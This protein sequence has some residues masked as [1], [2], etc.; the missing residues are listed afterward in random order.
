MKFMPLEP[1][2]VFV[3]GRNKDINIRHCANINLEADEQVTFVTPSGTEYDVTY[4][5]WGYYATPSLNGRLRDY[6]LRAVLIRNKSGRIYLLLVEKDS[7]VEFQSYLAAEEQ[8]IV[9]WLDNDQAVRKIV[10]RLMK[11]E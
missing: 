11:D 3:V 7:E 4:K 10:N 5:S 6:G 9:C 1:P 8:E 2:R